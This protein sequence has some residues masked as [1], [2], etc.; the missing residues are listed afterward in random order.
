MRTNR[1]SIVQNHISITNEYM[2]DVLYRYVQMCTLD[3]LWMYHNI[4]LCDACG[5]YTI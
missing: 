2:N 4:I 3:K 1:P 5:I